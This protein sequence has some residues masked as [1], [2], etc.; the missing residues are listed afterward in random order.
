MKLKLTLGLAVLW[1][2]MGLRALSGVA[3]GLTDTF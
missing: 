2:V 3:K 1:L